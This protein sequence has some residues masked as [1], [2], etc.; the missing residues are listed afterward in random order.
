VV[1]ALG[2]IAARAARLQ[3]PAVIVIGEA[4]RWRSASLLARPLL[5]AVALDCR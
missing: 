4:R 1:G 3:A 2:D 5:D